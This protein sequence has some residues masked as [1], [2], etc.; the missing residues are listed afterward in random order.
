M[1]WQGCP[2]VPR[3][4]VPHACICTAVARTCGTYNR[5][6]SGHSGGDIGVSNHASQAMLSLVHMAGCLWR[7]Y[8]LAGLVTMVLQDLLSLVGSHRQHRACCMSPMNTGPAVCPCACLSHRPLILQIYIL[9]A[10]SEI[11]LR[12]VP[13]NPND[14]YS[15]LVQAM[16]WCREATSHY[17]NQCWPKSLSSYGVT[18]PQ[19]VKTCGHVHAVAQ[20]LSWCDGATCMMCHPY[21]QDLLLVLALYWLTFHLAALLVLSKSRNWPHYIYLYSWKISRVYENI[22]L[23]NTSNQTTSDIRGP[24]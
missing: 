24:F 7:V 6:T 2:N 5:V 16:A 11:G 17:L 1:S 14:D 19:W 4:N 20:C 18:R 3:L 22:S 23:I 9:S 21:M 10:F 13:Q 15:T 8:P 12:W